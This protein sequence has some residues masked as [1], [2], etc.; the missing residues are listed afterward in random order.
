[1]TT[2]TTMAFSAPE[3]VSSSNLSAVNEIGRLRYDCWNSEGMGALDTSLFPDQS[4]VD[5]MDFGSHARHWVV[6]DTET[7]AIVGAARLTRHDSL[8]DDYRDVKLWKE[9]NIELVPP[10]VDFGRLVVAQAFRR[11]GI[12]RALVHARMAAV[13]SW[14]VDGIRAASCVCTASAANMTVLLQCGWYA[15]GQEVVFPD[16]PTTVFHALQYDI[17][18]VPEE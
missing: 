1:M 18:I 14:R 2:T 6:R 13:K 12:A 4:W 7:K 10:V 15:I 11:R 8:D 16:R 17:D 9:K 5:E 3:E